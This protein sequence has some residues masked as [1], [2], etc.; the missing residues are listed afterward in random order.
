MRTRR[1]EKV[2]RTSDMGKAYIFVNPEGK[3]LIG[4]PKRRGDDNIKMGLNA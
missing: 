2:S 3:R 4:R 1:E